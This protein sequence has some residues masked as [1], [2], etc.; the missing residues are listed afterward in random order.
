MARIVLVF[1]FSRSTGAVSALQNEI[2]GFE[3]KGRAPAA[4][5]A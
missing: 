5:A 4:Y 2:Q 3:M 1:E